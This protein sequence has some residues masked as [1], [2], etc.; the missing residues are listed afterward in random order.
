M[1][2]L[3]FDQIDPTLEQSSDTF[4]ALESILGDEEVVAIGTPANVASRERGSIACHC[5]VPAPESS[6]VARSVADNIRDLL[7][8]QRINGV[9]IMNVT[10]PDVEMMNNGLWTAAAVLISYERDF[11]SAAA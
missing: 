5:F 11:Y 9:R 3:D 6:G 4:L 8:M 10:T 2:V 1:R 7:R